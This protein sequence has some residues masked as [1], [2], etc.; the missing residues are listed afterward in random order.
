M[1]LGRFVRDFFREVGLV[2]MEP[3]VVKVKDGRIYIT[4]GELADA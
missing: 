3:F 2:V 1:S 4:D